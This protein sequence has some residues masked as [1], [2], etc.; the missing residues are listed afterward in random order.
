[1]SPYNR[2][3]RNSAPAG[4]EAAGCSGS[5]PLRGALRP[6]NRVPSR[7]EYHAA[8]S[9]PGRPRSLGR[10]VD[11]A[12]ARDVAALAKW[13]RST[14]AR[15]RSRGAPNRLLREGLWFVWEYPRLPEPRVGT[16]YPTSYPW[17]PGAQA[18]Y[19]AAGGR[20]PRGGYGLAF[21][22]L[23]PTQLLVRDVLEGERLNAGQVVEMLR[24]RVMA[25]V[26]TR[27]EHDRLRGTFSTSW[28]SYD[29]DP[30]HRYRAHMAPAK[31]GPLV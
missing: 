29:A 20:T 5:Q 17:S 10:N 12:D 26:V 21:E 1:M 8:M 23:Y 11:L 31:F 3:T 9:Q 27:A 2:A 19:D 6:A 28:Q 22:H 25:A 24:A 4:H 30:W 16:K 18:A 7:N 15:G 13:C 14:L